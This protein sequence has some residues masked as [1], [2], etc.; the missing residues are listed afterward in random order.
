MVGICGSVETQHE[1]AGDVF[2]IYSVI[3][4]RHEGNEEYPHLI[5]MAIESAA[6]FGIETIV[7][8]NLCFDGA[9]FLAFNGDAELHLMNWVLAAQRYYLNSIF[10]L[11]NSIF[12]SPDALFI[13]HPKIV[14]EK[15][16]DVAFTVREHKLYPINN[17][18][19]F[20]KPAGREKI[21][22]FWD[23]CLT[24]CK[25]Y[26]LDIQ[27]WYGDQKSLADELDN[28]AAKRIGLDVLTLPCSIYNAHTDQKSGL[29]H[30]F[31]ARALIGHFKGKRKNR[32]E[33]YHRY[34]CG[35][36]VK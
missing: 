9:K 6:R 12:F 11:Q 31:L 27:G 17:G 36:S 1:P 33:N 32:M 8:G 7:V 28:G 34:L 30:A 29:D 14:F 15:N 18:V 4:Y 22:Q 20:L 10:F 19:I 35:L 26:P 3:T 21:V 13:H 23:R 25:E 24:R 2:M 5:E 16:F